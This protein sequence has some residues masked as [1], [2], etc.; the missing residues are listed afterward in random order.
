M[1]CVGERRLHPD[2]NMLALYEVNPAAVWV[3]K[4]KNCPSSTE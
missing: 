2:T 3:I 1:C 4:P